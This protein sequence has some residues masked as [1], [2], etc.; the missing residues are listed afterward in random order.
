MARSLARRC[1][2]LTLYPSSLLPLPP[3]DMRAPA[4]E[5]AEELA[6]LRDSSS[7]A[8]VGRYSSGQIGRQESIESGRY[9]LTA[10]FTEAL[11]KPLKVIKNR[12]GTHFKRT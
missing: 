10:R 2:P 1:Q 6:R 7:G 12:S 5:D 3:L 8:D 11:E 4:G 9:S